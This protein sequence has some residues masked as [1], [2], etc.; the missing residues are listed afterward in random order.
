[1]SQFYKFEVSFFGNFI[2]EHCFRQN[3]GILREN[4]VYF[5]NLFFKEYFVILCMPGEKE[6]AHYIRKS[7]IIESIR[8]LER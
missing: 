8:K 1:M 2:N 6:K 4:Y 3:N 5:K 7:D